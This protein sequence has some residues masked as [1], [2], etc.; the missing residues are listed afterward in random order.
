MVMRC[1]EVNATRTLV[2]VVL[3]PAGA[4]NMFQLER[5]AA[6]RRPRTS[7]IGTQMCYFPGTRASRLRLN[8]AKYQTFCFCHQVFPA[9]QSSSPFSPNRF[10]SCVCKFHL[11][12]FV[13]P[14]SLLRLSGSRFHWLPSHSLTLILMQMKHEAKE[15]VAKINLSLNNSRLNST[16]RRI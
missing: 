14:L 9:C 8:E 5:F 2:V 10:Y 15:N 4:L 3:S 13:F 11:I 16:L 6:Y 1:V 7:L 12:L